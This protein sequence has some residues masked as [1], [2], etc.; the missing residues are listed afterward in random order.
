[1]QGPVIRENVRD[2]FGKVNCGRDKY[3]IEVSESGSR[4]VADQINRVYLQSAV[5]SS[6]TDLLP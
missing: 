5:L 3:E 2:I 6:A 1:M 4:G